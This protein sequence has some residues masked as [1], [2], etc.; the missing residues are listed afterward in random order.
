MCITILTYVYHNLN[1]QSTRAAES[2]LHW[3]DTPIQPVTTKSTSTLLP[4]TL[5][6]SL[7]KEKVLLAAYHKEKS[8]QI[9]IIVPKM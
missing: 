4:V 7:M 6:V 3:T 1:L 9:T 2:R 5:G 8:T